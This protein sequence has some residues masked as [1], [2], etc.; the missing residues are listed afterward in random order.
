MININRYVHIAAKPSKFK[1]Y[2][3]LLFILKNKK[4]SLLIY[5][6]NIKRN[7]IKI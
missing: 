4:Y 1:K 6:N 7:L 3:N 5:Y 2:I